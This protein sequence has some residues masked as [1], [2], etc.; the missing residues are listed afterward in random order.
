MPSG[1]HPPLDSSDSVTSRKALERRLRVLER[2]CQRKRKDRRHRP[3]RSPS[4]RR[5][6]ARTRSSRSRSRS[7]RNSHSAERSRVT[8]RERARRL[9]YPVHRRSRSRSAHATAASTNFHATSTDHTGDVSP[10]AWFRVTHG[11]R[12]RRS[13][14]HRSHPYSTPAVGSAIFR[15]TSTDNIGDSRSAEHSPLPHTPE[16]ASAEDIGLGSPHGAVAPSADTLVVQDP[17]L[18][19]EILDILGADPSALPTSELSF[20]TAL[21]SRWIHFLTHGLDTV[22][23]KELKQ[24]YTVP[25][26]CAALQA[27]LLNPEL[28][29]ALPLVVGRKDRAASLTQTQLGLGLVPLGQAMHLLLQPMPSPPPDKL[30][31]L[32]SDAAKIITD[33]F[34]HLTQSRRHNILNSINKTAKETLQ[35][36][37]TDAYLFGNELGER[38]KAAKALLRSCN[39]L[40]PAPKPSTSL[41]TT[42]F[43]AAPSAKKKKKKGGGGYPNPPP[44]RPPSRPPPQTIFLKH[45]TAYDILVRLVGS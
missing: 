24:K 2:R 32:L 14:S 23:K 34:Y 31:A 38:L 18:E 43:P 7:S 12:T 19:A 25:A 45:Y 21:A 3:D 20:H 37:S 4:T 9:R 40:K 1:H 35:Q 15:A 41:L 22:V 28:R 26:N 44:A 6:R 17:L 36:A 5:S 10:A 8:H 30:L 29:P 42:R 39:D 16:G 27:P 13:P 11:D 33:S